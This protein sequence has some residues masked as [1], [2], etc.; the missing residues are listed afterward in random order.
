MNASGLLVAN[1]GEIA[2]RIIRAAQDLGIRAVAIHSED[3]ANALHVRKADEARPL[4]GRGAAPYL[5]IDQVVEAALRAECDA[6]HP[7]YGFLAENAEFARRCGEAGLTFV[8]P[9]VLTLEAFG[10]KVR[11]RAIAA[12]HGVPVLPG[13][14]TATTLD[15]ARR[16]YEELPAGSAMMIK[17]VAGGGGRG[18]RPVTDSSRLDELYARC[19]SEARLSFGN[20]ALYVERLIP[21]A[22][23]IEVQILGDGTGA[24]T[25]FRERE[26]SIQ[27]RYQKIVE[28]APAPHLPAGLRQR[29]I[30]A[31]VRMA[32]GLN[33][34][35]LGTFEFLVDATQVRDDG[36]FFF[37]ETNARLQVEHTVTEEAMGI[38]LVQ[39]QLRVADGATLAEL[40]LEQDAVLPPRG[41]AIQTRVNMETMTSDGQVRPSGGVLAAFDPPHGPGVRVDTFGYAG[42][43]TSPSFDSLLAKVI[44][45]SP[46]SSF[47]DAVTRAYRTLSE[48]RIDG[49]S[50]N[51]PFLQN[52]L[53][54]PD[55]LS[56]NTY[57]TFVDD[58]IAEL[59]RADEVHPRRFFDLETAH[60]DEAAAPPSGLAGAQI[61]RSDPL[62][63]LTFGQAERDKLDASRSAGGGSDTAATA[64]PDG[65]V[66]LRSP[67]QGTVV[68]VLV[69]PGDVVRRGQTLLIME[70]M[71]ME[72]EI[73]ADRSGVVREIT[74]EPGDIVV[75][76]RPLLFI[77]EAEVG[78]EALADEEM[79]DLDEIRPDLQRILD[80]LDTT[81]DH[82]RQW[83]VERR[84]AR[85]QRT[86]RE[87]IAQLLDDDQPFLEWGQLVLAAQSRRRTLEDLIEKT[88]ADGMVTG[89][90]IVNGDLFD[91]PHSSVAVIAYDYTVL[92]GTQGSRNH[93]K[94]DRM[95]KVAGW[96]RMPLV[97]FAE[98]GGGRPGD[99][100]E[101]TG[102][103][104]EQGSFSALARLSGLVPLVG[105]TSGR[106][107]AG[108][109]AL[110]GICD[111][112]IATANS[113]IGMG[114]PAM[115]EG[116]NLGIFTPEEVGPMSFQVPNGVVDIAVEDE[117]EA[118]EVAKRYLSYF[119]GRRRTWETHDQRLLRRIVPEHRLRIYDIRK[120]IE[121]IAD[122][123]S[124]LELRPQ[125]GL[126]M[127]TAFARIEGRPIG[128]VAN[129]PAH[130]GGAID[131]DAGDKAARFMQICD[132]F[133]IPILFLSDTPGIMVGP[134]A[135]KGA[136]VRH[137]NRMLV[138]G[139]NLTVPFFTIVL[140][141]GYGIG[142]IAMGG[143]YYKEPLFLVS[144]PTG[145]FGGMGLEGQVKLGFRNELAA[146]EDPE[147]RL[148]EYE[149]LVAEAYERGGALNVA[150]SF[151]IDQVIDPAE[152]RTWVANILR[153]MRPP[154]P[155]EGKKRPYIDTW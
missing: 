81:Y 102:G 20:G 125:F 101:P 149:R 45:H 37:I 136:L 41:Y 130:I 114:G 138:A 108:N 82:S 26:C 47:E 38:D 70:A 36:E 69:G 29:I 86:T 103:P 90:G 71:K 19:E 133:D 153:A 134:E 10:D 100:D 109:T 21:R 97:F 148:K 152:S 104:H 27:R 7:G 145:E 78:G 143:G 89:V 4:S 142:A 1:R 34:R 18:T 96:G 44:V 9:D 121:T 132:A 51:I 117:V 137:A 31:A 39:A 76:G 48:F 67:I 141:K 154:A 13:T 61:D 66:A 147:E 126:A 32:T 77:E 11:A 92:A 91:E 144:W 57:T 129:N 140:R 74:V 54:H 139:P 150:T 65:T 52:L 40:H 30:Q 46:S 83:A 63:V 128:I 49:V 43:R 58:H 42:Y 113:T 25:H 64:G 127:V 23:H 62:A 14:S 55:F 105:I 60:A 84:R 53:R 59:A 94:T 123:D 17:A 12:E 110:L 131:A 72:H 98:G 85:G 122:I 8:G 2:V 73:A 22:R 79:V 88:S 28:I 120:V 111:V 3:D 119:Q 56:G 118:V 107:F 15:D 106:C 116:G 24:V 155:R 99:T 151:G 5:D 6:V 75:E 135:E 93:R 112:I 68:S 95:L 16:F 50:T 146:I 33:Y 35:S 115:I 87:N 80:R 124:V